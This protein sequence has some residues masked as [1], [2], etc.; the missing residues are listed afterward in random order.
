V[1]TPQR[2]TAD[3]GKALWWCLAIF[4]GLAILGSFVN[5]DNKSGS[6]SVATAKSESGGNLS[7]NAD[8]S[9]ACKHF[10]N[11]MADINEGIL[12]DSEIRSKVQEVYNDAIT[13][14]VKAAASKLL[15]DVTQRR[16]YAIAADRDALISA[17]K[18]GKA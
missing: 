1:T 11:I 7:Y 13:A 2:S 17:C 14:P 12:N 4:A 16:T 15:A 3:Q 10:N 18:L 9:L 6:G 8:D 5:N